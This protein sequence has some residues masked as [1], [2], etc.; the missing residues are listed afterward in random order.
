MKSSKKQ[1]SLQKRFKRLAIR[2]SSVGALL[3]LLL[4]L[5][6][7][8]L[9]IKHSSE[10]QISVVASTLTRAFRPAILA[11][12]FRDAKLQIED[13]ANLKSGESI[14]IVD[15]NYKLAMKDGIEAPPASHCAEIN[16]P[17]W[18]DSFPQVSISQAIYFND[19]SK[20]EIFGYLVLRLSPTIDWLEI[21]F[22]I[23]SG[24]IVFAFQVR[25][26]YTDLT[27]ES[28]YIGEVLAEWKKQIDN[29]KAE[30]LYGAD[31]P[32]PDEFLPLDESIKLLHKSVD[33]LENIA[34]SNAAVKAKIDIVRGLGHDLK[35]PLSQLS[36]YF[37]IFVA[38][39]ERNHTINRSE[40]INIEA[41]LSRMGA[42][43]K[44]VTNFDSKVD[45]DSKTG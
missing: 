14:S 3:T 20:K 44:Q 18:L 8:S 32:L 40:V 41:S 1:T 9:V 43:I 23:L 27:L 16:T 42:V 36:K 6:V 19:D 34:A 33:D 13:V 25:K 35:T 29:P 28:A 5:P 21:L 22:I 7:V 31:Y 11:Y 4:I 39:T 30:R 37:A 24:F 17:C 2:W 12:R 45:N 26:T 38:N 10:R 15:E